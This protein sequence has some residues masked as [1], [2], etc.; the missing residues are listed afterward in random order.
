[1]MKQ[2]LFGNLIY[3]PKKVPRRLKKKNHL[4]YFFLII[5]IN[6]LVLFPVIM[7]KNLWIFF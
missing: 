2:L 3:Y 6:F 1:M 4:S 7:I 5:G